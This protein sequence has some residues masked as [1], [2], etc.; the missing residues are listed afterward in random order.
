MPK[1]HKNCAR[2]SRVWRA[3]LIRS[4]LESVE[5]AASNC[6]P[7]LLKEWFG[8]GMAAFESQISAEEFIGQDSRF[9]ALPRLQKPPCRP[10][11]VGFASLAH[12][13][14]RKG[15][16]FPTHFELEPYDTTT[17]VWK[18][19]FRNNV[20]SALGFRF[21]QHFWNPTYLSGK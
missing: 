4:A 3:I 14:M 17:T 1:V 6:A 20:F 13:W 10:Q 7:S 16:S 2:R 15:Q 9:W 18:A 21:T 19:F 8:A 12:R 11:C 5:P